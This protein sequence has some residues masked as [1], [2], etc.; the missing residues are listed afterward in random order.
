MRGLRGYAV[1]SSFMFQAKRIVIVLLGNFGLVYFFI[2]I[3]IG[4]PK[5]VLPKWSL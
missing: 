3:V 4:K 1:I 2:T 5:R